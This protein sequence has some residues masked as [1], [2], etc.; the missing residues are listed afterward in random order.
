MIDPGAVGSDQSGGQHRHW[1]V[2]GAKVTGKR[3]SSAG[4]TDLRVT[5]SARRPSHF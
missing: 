4:V 3:P 5:F 2:N 1:L